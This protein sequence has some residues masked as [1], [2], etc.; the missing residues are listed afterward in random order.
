MSSIKTIL[1]KK[2]LSNGKYPISLRVT[3]DRKSK[4]FSTPFE[5][6]LNEWDS[7]LGRF[8]KKHTL[9]L[10]SN[11]LLGKIEDRALEVISELEMNHDFYSLNDFERNLERNQI[12]KLQIYFHF[13]KSKL[14][15]LKKQGG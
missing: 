1:R 13:G 12:L 6:N 11:R 14:M 9:Q 5:S 3:K 8:N 2:K 4:F 10:K 15:N 7:K